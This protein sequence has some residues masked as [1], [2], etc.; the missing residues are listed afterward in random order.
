MNYCVGPEHKP[1]RLVNVR[2]AKLLGSYNTVA[3][4]LREVA[5]GVSLNGYLNVEHIA[6]QQHRPGQADE[7]LLE[8][9]ALA[10][11]AMTSPC[12]T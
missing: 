11:I 10:E 3:E 6:L 1:F 2:A 8:G 9:L 5:Y 4:A 7:P 12:Q